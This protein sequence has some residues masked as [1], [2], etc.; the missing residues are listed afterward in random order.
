MYHYGEDRQILNN[1]KT[2]VILKYG[3]HTH[4]DSTRHAGRMRGREVEVFFFLR[5][6]TGVFYHGQS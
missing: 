4:T 3:H 5:F 2:N 1:L 6:G